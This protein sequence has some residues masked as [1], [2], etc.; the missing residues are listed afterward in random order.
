MVSCPLPFSNAQWSIEY[1][2]ACIEPTESFRPIV[3]EYAI[4]TC[5]E[6]LQKVLGAEERMDIYSALGDL[7]TLRQIYCRQS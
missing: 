4:L 3:V 2:S 1:H 7:A 6:A 5:N